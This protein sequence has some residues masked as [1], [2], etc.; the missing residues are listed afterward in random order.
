V[1]A[2]QGL[3][4][5][6]DR[7]H[8]HARLVHDPLDRHP[9]REAVNR[10]AH[11]L[12]RRILDAGHRQ[13]PPE[14]DAAPGRVADKVAADLVRDAGDRHVLL[15]DRQLDEVGVRQRDLAVD[16]ALHGQR[17]CR[18]V[19]VRNEDRGV[20]AVEAGVRD[21]DGRLTLDAQVGAGRQRRGLGRLGQP[22]D[23]HGLALALEERL[24][25]DAGGERADRQAAAPDEECPTGPVGHERRPGR[26]RST[27]R[28]GRA[29]GEGQELAEDPDADDGLEPGRQCRERR[30]RVRVADGGDEA[31][32]RESG[33][34]RIG[35]RMAAPG[36]DAE[37]GA[38]GQRS[39]HDDDLEGELVVRAEQAR[40]E[41]LG[42][43]WLEGDDAPADREHGR[44]R[45]AEE[46]GREL[47]GGDRRADGN[48]AG[49]RQ[50]AT[51]RLVSV[52]ARCAH[53]ARDY[54]RT[55]TLGCQSAGSKRSEAPGQSWPR[56]G[57]SALT[58]TAS[59]G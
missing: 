50:Q 12:G 45:P 53:S 20:D 23:R 37:A 51:P 24:A 4:V 22:A 1:G 33:D 8:R 41:V 25:R 21:D 54:A 57:R 7:D 16:E 18:D 49:E 11:E 3:A 31:D 42:P 44:W 10:P 58:T 38:D 17:P 28:T 32:R 40:D 2:R 30:I 5:H 52:P 27:G 55:V 13:H 59:T 35:E 43:G 48:E 26:G 29:G 14:L 15:D 9:D 19:D 39:D 36:K 6:P 34:D 47:A 46:A 56:A